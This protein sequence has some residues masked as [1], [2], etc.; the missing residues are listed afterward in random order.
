MMRPYLQLSQS[1]TA[2]RLFLPPSGYIFTTFLRE[3][4][5]ARR[6]ALNEHPVAWPNILPL[7]NNNWSGAIRQSIDTIARDYNGAAKLLL[8]IFWSWILKDEEKTTDSYFWTVAREYAVETLFKFQNAPE[9][10]LGWAKNVNPRNQGYL[11]GIVSD[12]GEKFFTVDSQGNLIWLS[13]SEGL[14]LTENTIGQL[15]TSQLKFI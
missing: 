9:Q 6:F 12:D 10:Y 11:R 3:E 2:Q 13:E 15:S 4:T 1:T 7:N 5:Q 14:E 8:I